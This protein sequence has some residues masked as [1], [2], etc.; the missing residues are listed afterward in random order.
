MNKP[1]L[2]V[3]RLELFLAVLDHGG[4]GRAARAC[5]ISQ[6]AVSEHLQG[7]AAYFGVALLERRGRS[8]R[9]TPAARLLESYARQAVGL[10]RAAE[11]AAADL[12]GLRSGALTVG[13]STTPG[14][15]LLPAALGRF[16]AAHPALALSLQ[17]SDSREIER[18]VAVGE[19]ELAV[20][21]EAPLVS[22]L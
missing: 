19:L 4:V 7:L 13:A 11:R 1:G 8:V 5:N 3:H 16:H 22:G 2:T 20:I 17:I 10:L 15:Y 18:S 14:T 12:Q 9:P 6:P 21:G